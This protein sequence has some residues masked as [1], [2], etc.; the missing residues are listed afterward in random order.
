MVTGYLYIV[1]ILKE[2]YVEYENILFEE[3][4][5][6]A[7]ITLNRPKAF[8]AFNEALA[9]ELL[10][11]MHACADNRE[12]RSVVVTGAGKSFCAGGDIKEFQENLA[13]IGALLTKLTGVIH[14]TIALMHRMPKPVITAVN[15]MVAG[16]GMGLALAGDVVYASERAKFTMAY[17][18]IGASP[19]GGSSYMLPK[20]VG[21]RRAFELTFENPVLSA[22]QAKEW[23]LINGV[24]G[25]SETIFREAV[26]DI[27]SM[28]ASGPTEAYACAKELLYKSY[29]ET[30]ESQMRLEAA[31]IVACAQTSDFKE[32]L[33][34]FAEKRLPLFIG[35]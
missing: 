33:A 6:V 29:S 15:G 14:H 25:G 27:A 7:I 18:N 26:M 35:S 22:E 5:A 13:Y 24:I 19:D 16:G 1:A 31:R 17:T 10:E 9:E 32:G 23:R 21:L 30:F 4:G 34:A 12:I 11:A 8:N 3:V 20:L 28:L 2:T